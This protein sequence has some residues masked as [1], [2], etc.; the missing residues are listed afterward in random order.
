MNRFPRSPK[1][2]RDALARGTPF[3]VRNDKSRNDM[4]ARD[5]TSPFN[6]PGCMSVNSLATVY[7]GI[8]AASGW[9][10]GLQI[11]NAAD[12]WNYAEATRPMS[13][14]AV[15]ISSFGVALLVDSMVQDSA[16]HML[17]GVGPAATYVASAPNAIS[18][19]LARSAFT[20]RS[21]SSEP[22]TF[23]TIEPF[24]LSYSGPSSIGNDL[25]VGT[26]GIIGSMV[27][28]LNNSAETF[29]STLLIATVASLF[30]T[31]PIK[32]ASSFIA[33]DRKSLTLTMIGNTGSGA[34]TNSVAFAPLYPITNTFTL[35][36]AAYQSPIRLTIYP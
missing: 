29:K 5:N 27:F 28:T 36:K 14:I 13:E 1:S 31:C 6:T 15:G 18:M 10:Q 3:F 33:A 9:T 24:S 20:G 23:L 11:T 30:A 26:T 8:I 19:T 2:R 16:N 7:E 22:F 25:F 17:V 21:I 35:R 32:V 12:T 4:L 34:F